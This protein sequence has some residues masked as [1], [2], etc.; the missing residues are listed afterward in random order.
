VKMLMVTSLLLY[1]LLVAA[2]GNQSGV[3][4]GASEALVFTHSVKLHASGMYATAGRLTALSLCQGG[5]G[6]HCMAEAV[7]RYM[8]GLDVKDSLLTVELVADPD[9]R[10][11]IQSVRH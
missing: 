1:S 8:C 10:A 3:F 11:R 5:P 2:I 9:I 7:Y 4:E 6:L